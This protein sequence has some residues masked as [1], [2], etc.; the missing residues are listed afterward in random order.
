MMQ[1]RIIDLLLKVTCQLTV[2]TAMWILR[3]PCR[4]LILYEYSRKTSMT[5]EGRTILLWAALLTLTK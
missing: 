3:N 2:L 5:S 1:C 4:R